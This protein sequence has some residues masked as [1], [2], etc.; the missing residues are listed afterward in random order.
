MGYIREKLL[1]FKRRLQ[2]RKMYSII[3]VIVAATA[4]FGIYQYKNASQLRQ[5]L[6]VGVALRRL[7]LRDGCLAHPHERREPLLRKPARLAK[8]CDVSSNLYCAHGKTSS[9]GNTRSDVSSFTP[10]SAKSKRFTRDI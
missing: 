8:P 3:I 9:C 2:D 5:K 1:D 10:R 6:D 7:P 4:V